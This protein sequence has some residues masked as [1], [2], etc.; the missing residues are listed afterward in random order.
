LAASDEPLT[1][2]P[3]AML[4]VG[5]G[6]A[7]LDGLGAV[8]VGLLARAVSSLLFQPQFFQL[9]QLLLLADGQPQAPLRQPV[10]Q[11]KLQRARAATKPQ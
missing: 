6:V 9:S 3:A 10:A 2:V 8:V 1:P 4:V 5:C 7:V 11:H